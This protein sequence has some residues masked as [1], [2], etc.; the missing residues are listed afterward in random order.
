M[1]QLAGN[2]Q[3]RDSESQFWRENLSKLRGNYAT[4]GNYHY[5]DSQPTAS[6]VAA[7]PLGSLAE[8]DPADLS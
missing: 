6:L 5:R 4:R 3:C 8:R 2:K 7:W 1:I